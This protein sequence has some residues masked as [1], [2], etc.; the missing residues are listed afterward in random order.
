MENKYLMDNKAFYSLKPVTRIKFLLIHFLF[1]ILIKVESIEAARQLVASADFHQDIARRCADRGVPGSDRE[2]DQD[3]QGQRHRGNR[4][5][6]QGI[7][8]GQVSEHIQTA[9][10]N[11][12]Q[13]ATN[14]STTSAGAPVVLRD[15]PDTQMD[16]HQFPPYLGDPFGITRQPGPADV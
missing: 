3:A 8:G 10:G 11:R 7:Q 12:T 14:A 2:G 13:L 5:G 9:E 1:Q 16:E 4:R 15:G 6:G